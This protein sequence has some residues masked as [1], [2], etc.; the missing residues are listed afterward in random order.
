MTPRIVRSLLAVS[1]LGVA[2]PSFAADCKPSRWGA[3]DQIGNANLI[4]PESVLM[5]SKLIKTGKTYPL[6][7]VIDATTPAFP[8][9]SLSLQVVQPGQQ[10]GRTAFP[11]AIYND[12]LVQMWLV[13]GPQFD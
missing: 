1:L 4:T 10:M 7:I 3:D 6:G 13:I 9:R 8:P 2:S 11:N 12:D 5:A